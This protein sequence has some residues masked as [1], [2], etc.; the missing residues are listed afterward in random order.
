MSELTLEAAGIA[1]IPTH[2]DAPEELWI[3]T[4]KDGDLPRVCTSAKDAE[5]V[6]AYRQMDLKSLAPHFVTHY[7]KVAL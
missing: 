7:R 2:K 1:R 6:R 4:D 5:T 3:V